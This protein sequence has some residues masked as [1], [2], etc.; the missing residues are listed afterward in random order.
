[1]DVWFQT[2][3]LPAKCSPSQHRRLTEIF[4]LCAEMY[5]ACLESW[6]GTYAWWKEHHDPQTELFPSERNQSKYDLMRQFTGVREDIAEWNWLSVKVGRGVICRFDRARAAFYRR[7]KEGK[8]PGFPRFK[9][10][11]R[12]CSI[13]IPDPTSSMVSAPGTGQNQS[14]RWWRLQVRG[15]PQ[16]RF[17]DQSR[18]LATALGLGAEVVELRVVRTPLRTEVH[19][20]VKHPQRPIAAKEP[21]N[22]VGIDLGLHTRLHTSDRQ[23]LPARAVDRSAI[24]K[25]QRKVS[26]AKKGSLSRRKR[27]TAHAKVWRREKER[28][29]QADFRLAHHLV[30]TYDS[31]AVE[32]LNVSGML[33]SKRFSKKMSEQRWEALCQILE[34]KAWKAGVR[35]VRVNPSHTSTDC[36]SCGHRQS[37]PLSV[38]VYKGGG[39]GL[40]MCR[41]HNA[42]QNICARGFP[43][44]EPWDRPGLSA[45][46]TRNTNFCCKTVSLSGARR[47]TDDAEQYQ[48]AIGYS[49]I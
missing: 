14:E 22:P 35:Y 15:V 1:M 32:D 40:V 37:M 31:I 38:R 47:Q 13:E 2:M 16:L 34:H 12:W 27:V 39:C 23:S 6:K 20:V 11:H 18:R 48:S 42:A 43:H 45:D 30:N 26:R 17:S 36:S 9:P 46:V 24:K 29:R 33:R 28:A 49:G 25:T 5:N 44:R 10:R 3:R 8:A 21:D 19:E 4:G 41:D 7:C